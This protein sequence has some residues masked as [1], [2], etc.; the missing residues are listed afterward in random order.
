MNAKVTLVL[1]ILAGLAAV[2]LVQ[3]HVSNLRGDTI[4]VYKSTVTQRAGETLGS[5]G[6]EEITL[7]AGLFPSMLEDAP[8][9]K[10][11]D[12]VM[13]T[14]LREPVKEGDLLLFRHFDSSVDRGV[15]PEIPAGM[16]AIS[17]AVNEES[18]VAYFIQPGD[19]VD[20]LGTFVGGKDASGP[21]A[22]AE[23]FDVS[24]RPIVQAVK[25]LAVG[26]H[27]RVS[28]RQ[29]REPYS[30]VTLLVSM[31]EAAN[32]SGSEITADRHRYARLR[33]NR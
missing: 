22:N 28:Q 27:Y 11:A 23:M 12:L 5:S 6:V 17:I 25:V 10:L 20:V 15:T 2:F 7:P 21:Q 16:K 30:S 31:E 33:Q 19:L 9:S 24:T 26:D 13:N 3:T 1:A 4:T 32:R 14:P 18:S 29:K 8:T